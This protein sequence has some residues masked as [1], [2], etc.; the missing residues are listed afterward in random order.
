MFEF[1]FPYFPLWA[2]QQTLLTLPVD[3]LLCVLFSP[4]PTL[5]P[6]QA[7]LLTSLEEGHLLSKSRLD[8]L[9]LR[10]YMSPV[11]SGT[12]WARG[13]WV[14]I[15]HAGSRDRYGSVGRCSFCTICSKRQ[16]EDFLGGEIKALMPEK[17]NGQQSTS[18]GHPKKTLALD[19]RV[20]FEEFP[21]LIKSHF[22]TERNPSQC[23][24]S[25]LLLIFISDSFFVHSCG[26]VLLTLETEQSKCSRL[27]VVATPVISTFER[28]EQEVCEL[29]IRV[30]ATVRPCFRQTREETAQR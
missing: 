15:R 12:L 17:G 2:R 11:K 4:P 3:F 29:Q 26:F 13:W 30:G 9:D 14:L 8:P 19:W 7:E 5:I 23:P 18:P 1:Y 20:L 22:Q 16:W 21:G 27:N 24:Y 6:L 25:S 28:L 10:G